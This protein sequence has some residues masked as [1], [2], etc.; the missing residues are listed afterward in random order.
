MWHNTVPITN[1]SYFCPIQNPIYNTVF[2]FP[3][4]FHNQKS[5]GCIGADIIQTQKNKGGSRP[6]NPGWNRDWLL[7][8]FWMKPS[9]YIIHV[10][11]RNEYRPNR[12]V[13][14]FSANIIENIRKSCS[15]FKHFPHYQYYVHGI[16]VPACFFCSRPFG[17]S[18]YGKLLSVVVVA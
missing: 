9:I 5:V 3:D 8:T 16:S 10:F 13:S 11:C 4:Q 14:K 17:N 2:M 7:C 6:K 1:S 12:F 18:M 15:R